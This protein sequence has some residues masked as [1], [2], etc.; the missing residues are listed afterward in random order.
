MPLVHTSYQDQE[1]NLLKCGMSRQAYVYSLWWA[2]QRI[3]P[4]RQTINLSDQTAFSLNFTPL[5]LIWDH[6]KEL[7]SFSLFKM[8]TMDKRP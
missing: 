6:F 7:S 2:A 3:S 5:S 1:I 8:S 4:F